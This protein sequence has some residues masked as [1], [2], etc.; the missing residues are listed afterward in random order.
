ML[1]GLAETLQLSCMCEFLCSSWRRATLRCQQVKKCLE[2]F[3]PS[4]PLHPLS[5]L[6][7]RLQP[8]EKRPRLD[9]PPSPLRWVGLIVQGL[10]VLVVEILVYC[11]TEHQL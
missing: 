11:R 4:A 1:F 10:Y 5:W 8:S 9:L 3:P 7:E 2:T 6:M